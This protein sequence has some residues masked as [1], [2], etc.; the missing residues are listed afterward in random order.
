[1]AENKMD[2]DRL[3]TK[4]MRKITMASNAS[5]ICCSDG[6]DGVMTEVKGQYDEV[7]GLLASLI[8]IYCQESG[9]DLDGIKYDMNEAMD[10]IKKQ[11]SKD[12]RK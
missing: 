1:M 10:I 3:V 6:K 8:C 11:V 2:R 7:I 9:Y 4:Y 12:G 5:V